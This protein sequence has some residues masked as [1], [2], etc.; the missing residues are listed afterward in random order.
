MSNCVCFA[1]APIHRASAGEIMSQEQ[2][3]QAPER[4]RR[5]AS[6][7]RAKQGLVDSELLGGM[8][9]HSDGDMLFSSSAAHDEDETE[10]L[11]RKRK[12]KK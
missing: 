4:P 11:G 8:L 9:M 12:K 10:G 1:D 5:Q 3:R 2:S 6:L 7:S